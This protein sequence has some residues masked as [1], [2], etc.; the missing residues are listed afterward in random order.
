MSVPMLSWASLDMPGAKSRISSRRR[1]STKIERLIEKH[2]ENRKMF[3]AQTLTV[4]NLFGLLVI[5]RHLE[6][7][8]R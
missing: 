8:S 4:V 5:T 7:R 2:E 1:R 3:Y 6:G